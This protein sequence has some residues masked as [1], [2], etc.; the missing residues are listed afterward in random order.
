MNT[1]ISYGHQCIDNEDI[2]EVIKVLRSPWVTQGPRIKEFEQA[3]A[4]YCG[5]RYCAAFSSGTAALH[6]AYFA[7]DIGKGDEIITSPITFA[8]TANAALYLN[9]RPVFADIQADTANLDPALLDRNVTEKTKAIVP[10]HFAGQPVDLD[11]IYSFA[12]KHDLLVI[13]D[14]CHALGAEYKGKK[15]GSLSDLTVFSFHPVKTITSGEGGAVLTN[16]KDLYEK[17]VMFRNHGVTRDRNRLRNDQGDWFYEMHYLGYNYRITDFQCALATS[18]MKKLD[19]FISRRREIVYRYD[20]A[21]ESED[22][23]DLLHQKEN[24]TSAFHIYV[25]CLKP[26][27]LG[28]SRKEAFEYLRNRGIGVQVHYIPV[29]LHPYYQQMGYRKGLCPVAEDYYERAITI[30]LHPSMEKKDVD[31][32]IEEVKKAT[33]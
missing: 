19:R 8:A 18:Q 24:R 1:L 21:F 28:R 29:Y 11:E 2:E 13:E 16:K 14:A 10:I 31:R 3:L 7:A 33:E 20:K 15:I 25:I 22:N 27:T 6:A 30:P 23:I 4:T 5:A 17:M 32:V 9:A 26:E 12:E